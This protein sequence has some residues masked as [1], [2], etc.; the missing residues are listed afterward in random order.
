MVVAQVRRRVWKIVQCHQWTKSHLQKHH[1]W[2]RQTNRIIYIRTEEERRWLFQDAEGGSPRY[3]GTG[4]QNAWPIFHI[5]RQESAGTRRNPE[6]IRI[7]SKYLNNLREKSTSRQQWTLST[8]ASKTISMPKNNLQWRKSK[9]KMTLLRELKIWESTEPKTMRVPKS[10]WRLRFNSL[11]NITKKWRHY[12]SWTLRSW[13]IIWK[14][15]RRRR[16]RIVDL[17]QRWRGNRDCWI[18][19]WGLSRNNT[20]RVRRISSNKTRHWLNNT[21]EL[22]GNL[23]IF[24]GNLSIF[25][26]LTWIDTTRFRLWMRLRFR[27][28]RKRL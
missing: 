10:D 22:L 21:R 23:R 27:V 6:K 20:T 18:T 19:G 13:I 9:L 25:R 1:R 11:K 2:Q 15:W 17:R 5:E 12:T 4:S 3:Q 14:C 8:S 26:R 28:W 7:I 16:T 24:R